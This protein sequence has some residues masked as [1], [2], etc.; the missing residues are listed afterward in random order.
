MTPNGC[1]LFGCEHDS[2]NYYQEESYPYSQQLASF[3]TRRHQNPSKK[4]NFF[5]SSNKPK[6]HYQPNDFF[7]P[8]NQYPDYVQPNPQP[9]TFNSNRH[10][11]QS[12]Q[13]QNKNAYYQKPQQNSQYQDKNMYYP[14]QQNPS[15]IYDSLQGSQPSVFD[16]LRFS[17]NENNGFVGSKKNVKFGNNN[18]DRQPVQVVRHEH[19]HFHE[20]SNRNEYNDNH[21]NRGPVNNQNRGVVPQLTPLHEG[22]SFGPNNYPGYQNDEP[23]FRSSLIKV[24]NDED[25]AP[26]SDKTSVE[27]DDANSKDDLDGK[28]KNAFS[29]PT[30]RSLKRSKRD[31]PAPYSLAPEPTK[32]VEAVRDSLKY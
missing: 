11:Q 9:Q 8:S 1:G 10:P 24:D 26:E 16:A 6:R 2:D 18:Q 28:K 21:Q 17:K 29:F 15:S 20:N 32:N 23:R 30:S 12:S 4:N 7:K 27:S 13:Y 14:N 31:N 5:P 19:Y 22:I 25:I 3:N